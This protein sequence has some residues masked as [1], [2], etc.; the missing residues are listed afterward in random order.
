MGSGREQSG[1]YR[2]DVGANKKKYLHVDVYVGAKQDSSASPDFDGEDK[3]RAKQVK[4]L[5]RTYDD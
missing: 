2:E 3:I 1:E 5:L 4:R